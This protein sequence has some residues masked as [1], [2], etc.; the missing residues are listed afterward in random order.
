MELLIVQN[1]AIQQLVRARRFLRRPFALNN[2]PTAL[3]GYALPLTVLAAVCSKQLTQHW[4]CDHS[5][6]TPYSSVAVSSFFPWLV[7]QLRTVQPDAVP[8]EARAALAGEANATEFFRPFIERHPETNVI[9]IYSLWLAAVEPLANVPPSDLGINPAY[10]ELCWSRW[11]STRKTTV[12]R[13][14]FAPVFKRRILG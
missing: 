8:S 4:E 1:Y 10:T 2:Y 7:T 13:A 6:A 12:P 3:T 14:T 9:A 11:R 5:Q